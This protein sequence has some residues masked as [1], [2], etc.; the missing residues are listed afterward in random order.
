MGDG[1]VITGKPDESCNGEEQSANQG[2][3]AGALPQSGGRVQGRLLEE[4]NLLRGK[5]AGIGGKGE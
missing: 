5:E 4:N 2:R 1:P 3:V